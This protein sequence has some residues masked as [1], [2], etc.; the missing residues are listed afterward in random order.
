V[1]Q[2][3]RFRVWLARVGDR[4]VGAA[5]AYVGDDVIGVYGVAVAP[6]TRRHGYGAA[7]TWRATRV[8]PGLP[9]ALQPSEIAFGVYRR[10]GYASIGE[11][12]PWHRPAEPRRAR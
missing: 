6:S 1:L 10:L 5:M 2:D 7:L 12:T 9:A 8:E 11:F 4:S 3:P